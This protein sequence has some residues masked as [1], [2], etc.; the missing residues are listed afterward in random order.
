MVNNHGDDEPAQN[1]SK[2]ELHQKKIMLSIW[3]DYKGVVY[4][5]LVP[6]NRTQIF[7]ANNLRNWRNQSKRK[8]QNWQIAKE[9]CSTTT[10]RGFTHL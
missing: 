5:E 4:F 3:W 8:G 6:N 10:M 2:A 1:I 7:T 9:L